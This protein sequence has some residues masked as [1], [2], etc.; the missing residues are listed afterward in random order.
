[1]L[2]ASHVLSK[3]ARIGGADPAH[4]A[5]KGQGLG[6]DLSS[7]FRLEKGGGGRQ[8]TCGHSVLEVVGLEQE[9]VGY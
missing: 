3:T 5:V 6:P 4:V 1:V 2:L 7:L 9:T 8:R